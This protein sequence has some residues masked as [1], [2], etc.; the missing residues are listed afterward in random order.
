VAEQSRGLDAVQ[1]RGAVGHRVDVADDDRHNLAEAQGDDSEVVASQTQGRSAEQNAEAGG[2]QR[3]DRQ[4]D[5]ERDGEADDVTAW[6]RDVLY[7]FEP[8]ERLPERSPVRH[9]LEGGQDAISVGTDG[10]ERRVAEIEQSGETND[11]IEAERQSGIGRGVGGRVDVGVVVVDQGEGD[12]GNGDQQGQQL[13]AAGWGDPCQHLHGVDLVLEWV[14]WA[15][16]AGRFG[17]GDGRDVR[18]DGETVRQ[19]LPRS[20]ESARMGRSDDVLGVANGR[21]CLSDGPV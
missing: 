12:G 18:T 1:A 3:R 6:L 15:R 13:L 5:P 10:E 20:V 8:G 11:D 9:H 2:E 7:Q 16:E 14:R 19:I 17:F 21:S 4:H